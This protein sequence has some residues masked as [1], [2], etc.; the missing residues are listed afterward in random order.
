MKD[1]THQS[2]YLKFISS[3]NSSINHLCRKRKN[4]LLSSQYRDDE[5]Y[6]KCF[7]QLKTTDSLPWTLSEFTA[8]VNLQFQESFEDLPLRMVMTF[9]WLACQCHARGGDSDCCQGDKASISAPSNNDADDDPTQWVHTVCSQMALA[10][11]DICQSRTQ[12]EE[13]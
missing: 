12:R 1:P 8:F 6:E 3:G 5:W 2:T 11:E 13:L 4:S 10:L 7:S 9:H